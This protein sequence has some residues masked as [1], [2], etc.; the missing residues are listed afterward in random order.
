MISSEIIQ[1]SIERV[2]AIWWDS[3][4]GSKSGSWQARLTTV[5][6][7]SIVRILVSLE[8]FYSILYRLSIVFVISSHIRSF[9]L[10]RRVTT[11]WWDPSARS[12]SGSWY[13]ILTHT[14]TLNYFSEQLLKKSHLVLQNMAY[15]K[16]LLL[17]NL[18]QKT[19]DLNNATL[20]TFDPTFDRTS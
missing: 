12:K 20:I 14:L 15:A 17:L 19:I 9:E 16:E 2:K 7:I 10:I 8:S 18:K 1:T 6:T 11:T 13:A 4:A 5:K 3:I